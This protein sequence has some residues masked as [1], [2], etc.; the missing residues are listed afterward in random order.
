MYSSNVPNSPDAK[1]CTKCGKPLGI[2]SAIEFDEKIER[3]EKMMKDYD[4]KLAKTTEALERATTLITI[5][6]HQ[7]SLDDIA[8]VTPHHFTENKEMLTKE[9]ENLKKTIQPL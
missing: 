2:E 1:M 5:M 4:E 6:N 9:I 8:E 3:T 7:K